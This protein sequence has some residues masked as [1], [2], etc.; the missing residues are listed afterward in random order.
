M[1]D[2]GKVDQSAVKWVDVPA[3]DKSDK[4]RYVQ[5]AA[6]D[7]FRKLALDMV[8]G[9]RNQVITG[10]KFVQK[11]DTLYLSAQVSEVN[12]DTGALAGG[13]GEWN[14]GNYPEPDPVRKKIN[15]DEKV[16]SLAQLGPSQPY[17]VPEN[18]R[19]IKFDATSLPQDAGQAVIPFFDV[20]AVRH[21]TIRKPLNAIGILY[22]AKK[23]YGGF[24]SPT[25]TPW[26]KLYL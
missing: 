24:I 18:K 22:K 26:R 5:L 14:E 8:Y 19:Y 13:A 23:T 12:P 9:K 3:G 1:N 6:P 21:H 7:G 15:L 11:G 10:V 2:Q 25:I 4:S 17:N 16:S 20:Q